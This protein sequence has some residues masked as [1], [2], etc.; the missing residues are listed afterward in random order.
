LVLHLLVNVLSYLLYWFGLRF[1]RRG[2][3]TCRAAAHHLTAVYAL[4]LPAAAVRVARRASAVP[5]ALP[6][7]P[8]RAAACVCRAFHLL[9][10]RWFGWFVAF[11]WFAVSS[12]HNRALCTALRTH[13]ALTSPFRAPCSLVIYVYVAAL[14]DLCCLRRLFMV[15]RIVAFRV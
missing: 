7:V 1:V 5:S 3:C 13:A 10:L 6:R 9:R 2:G 11:V 8:R 12:P 15:A 4:P 14:R